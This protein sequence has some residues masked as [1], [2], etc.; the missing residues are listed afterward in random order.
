MGKRVV[1]NT[2][3]V[4]GKWLHPFFQTSAPTWPWTCLLRPRSRRWGGGTQCPG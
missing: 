4:L 3:W 2:E 1:L